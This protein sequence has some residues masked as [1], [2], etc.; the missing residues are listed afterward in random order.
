VAGGQCVVTTSEAALALFR[1]GW[2][3]GPREIDSKGYKSRARS[4][5]SRE[6]QRKQG[7]LKWPGLVIAEGGS[8]LSEVSDAEG[9]K[10]A[11]GEV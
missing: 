8:R 2:N 7:L 11:D 3:G 10:T 4:R 1:A 9:Y 5:F 6:I